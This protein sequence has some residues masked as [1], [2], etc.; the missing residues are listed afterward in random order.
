MDKGGPRHWA[1]QAEGIAMQKR[2][3]KHI[4]SCGKR[5]LRAVSTASGSL[6]RH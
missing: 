4:G 6:K 3:T 5:R 2:A 1:T